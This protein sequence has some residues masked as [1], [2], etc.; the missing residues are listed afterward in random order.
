MQILIT[1]APIE[2]EIV[3][4]DLAVI[5]GCLRKMTAINL[6]VVHLDILE[7]A[8]GDCHLARAASGVYRLVGT[9]IEGAK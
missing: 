8:R 9:F 1:T 6:Q 4:R 2:S 3:L 7:M 5:F